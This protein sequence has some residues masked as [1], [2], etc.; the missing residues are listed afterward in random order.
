MRNVTIMAALIS[1]TL[2]T[3]AL[4]AEWVRVGSTDSGSSVMEIDA[5]SIKR[6][7]DGAIVW[8]RLTRRQGGHFMNQM[9]VN[10]TTE[11]YRD[12]RIIVYEA[13][14]YSKDISSTVDDDWRSPVPDSLMDTAVKAVCKAGER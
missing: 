4:A 13:S 6:A 11:A 9:A 10:C 2:P 7:S 3:Q 12:I 5:A 14:G 8:A 1:A